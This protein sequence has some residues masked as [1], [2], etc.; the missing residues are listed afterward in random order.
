MAN[1]FNREYQVT[2]Q[3]GELKEMA[4]GIGELPNHFFVNNLSAAVLYC[5][6]STMPS[7]QLAE[8]KVEGNSA[9]LVARRSG[10]QVFYMYNASN[11]NEAKVLLTAFNEDFNPVVLSMMNQSVTLDMQGVTI[12]GGGTINEIKCSLPGGANSIGFV[13]LNAGSNHI[14]SVGVN[15]V[16]SVVETAAANINAY[17]QEI[18]EATAQLQTLTGD[19]KT[20][21]AASNEVWTAAK[22]TQLMA[23]VQNI[24][25][26]AGGE[27]FTGTLAIRSEALTGELVW[28]LAD[29]G[30]YINNL[31]YIRCTA[32]SITV[33][34][35][36]G[37]GTITLA[38]G[39][40]INDVAGMIESIVIS[41]VGGAG[42]FEMLYSYVAV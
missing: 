21:Q 29:E 1:G 40:V 28:N 7:P 5:G 31:N 41:P 6:I 13:G 19:L 35:N 12:E 15:S 20:L 24:A 8:M 38:E 16:P 33:A 10:S 27:E 25:A 30:K 39:D 36:N 22:I 34:M 11:T 42:S 18:A 23:A 9:K 37:G 14:G 4:F 26:V 17:M 2:I 32:G 3:P